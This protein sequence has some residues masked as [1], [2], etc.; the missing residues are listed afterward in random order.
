[1]ID[2]NYFNRLYTELMAEQ[3]SLMNEIRNNTGDTKPHRRQVAIITAILNQ[4][5]KWRDIKKK[6]EE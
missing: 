3:M 2:D 6:T 1:M 5:G 4:L